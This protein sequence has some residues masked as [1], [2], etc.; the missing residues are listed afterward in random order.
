MSFPP[1]NFAYKNAVHKNI[2]LFG[3]SQIWPT[4]EKE[5]FFP[6]CVYLLLQYRAVVKLEPIPASSPG[7][8]SHSEGRS[9]LYQTSTLTLR[10]M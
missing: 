4:L 10:A 5:P 1:L 9:S 3:V 7:L 6:F 8:H 2:S